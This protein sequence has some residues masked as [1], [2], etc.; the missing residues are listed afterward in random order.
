VDHEA[1]LS[2]SLTWLLAVAIGLTVANMYYLQPLLNQIRTD[3]RATTFAAS[4]LVTLSQLG[5]SLGLFFIVP[6]GDIFRRRTLIVIIVVASAVAMGAE[7]FVHSYAIFAVLCVLVGLGS[8]ASHVM[9]PFGA[10]LALAEQRGRVIGRLMTGLLA[11]VVLSRTLAGAVT[12]AFG[13]QSI[14]GVSALLMTILAV[15]LWRVLPDE[16]HRTHAPYRALVL[17]GSRLF[18]TS[19]LLRRRCWLG[20]TVFG[21]LTVMWTSLAFHL[22]GAP[23]HY[24][25]G[26]IGLF[27]L[28]AL[29]G[30]LAAN[31]A[32][33]Q[34]DQRRT[35]RSSV[36]AGLFLCAGF[37][38]MLWGASSVA[39]ICVGIVFIDVATQGMQ[40]T[41]QS[42]VY[43]IEPEQ[44]SSL[45]SVYMLSF[46]LGGTVGSLTTGYVYSHF[47]W[48]GSCVLGLGFGLA[49][50]VPAT[51]LRSEPQ[52]QSSSVD[53]R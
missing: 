48:R 31:V 28:V 8:V 25:S 38:V 42:I 47:G 50:L 37:V 52:H 40:I 22:A 49:A 34:A 32:G 30:V 46:F 21:G 14:Y 51:F 5:Y 39:A 3:F 11:G 18:M 43:T 27:G 26:V 44:R 29:G 53:H 4:L 17:R 12:A 13:W 20:G 10:D 24:S 1:G 7:A 19:S 33:H 45:N 36:V 6:L 9:V 15:L 35:R 2:R 41:N 16:E 23:F